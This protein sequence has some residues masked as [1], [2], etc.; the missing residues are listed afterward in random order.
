MGKKKKKKVSKTESKGDEF[1]QFLNFP[2]QLCSQTRPL[3]NSNL[4]EFQSTQS[5][6]IGNHG[7]PAKHH[8]QRRAV[9]EAKLC[10]LTHLSIDTKL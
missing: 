4:L 6:N 10:F 7:S 9:V 3:S 1:L 8:Q 2:F 5:L